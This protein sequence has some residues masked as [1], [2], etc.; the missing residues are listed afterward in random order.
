MVGIY[1]YALNVASIDKIDADVDMLSAY[2]H[3]LG[4]LTATVGRR[5]RYDESGK[6]LY[7]TYIINEGPR[8]RIGEIQI[9][10]NTYITE[11]SLRD[12]MTLRSGDEFN[13]LILRTD[14]GEIVYG[15]G[16]LGFIYTEVDPKTI[17]RDE[18]G[19][20]DLVFDI[21]E[22]D[23]WKVGRISVEIAGD[24]HLMKETTVLNLLDLRE[25][26]FIDRR[27]LEVSRRRVEASNWFETNPSIAEAPDIKVV[28]REEIL[29]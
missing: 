12:R 14:I 9:I 13:G 27:K 23:R 3:N 21:T 19:I 5:L 26:D 16:E 22:G 15:Y 17:L 10:G 25:G 18:S 7:V 1:P 28:P 29:R 6:W 2:Y 20:V 24:P 11:K 8:F 4:F